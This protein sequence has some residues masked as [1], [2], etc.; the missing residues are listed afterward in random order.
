[1]FKIGLSIFM[2]IQTKVI[3]YF[4]TF[5]Y[6]KN[7]WNITFLIFWINGALKCT[8]NFS[9]FHIL[10]N[11]Y[12]ASTIKVDLKKHLPINFK[13]I[14]YLLLLYY[15]FQILYSTYHKPN[16]SIDVF[17]MKGKKLSNLLSC[18][19]LKKCHIFKWDFKWTSFLAYFSML[20]PNFQ[21]KN[22]ISSLHI[23]KWKIC[24]FSLIVSFFELRANNVR[25]SYT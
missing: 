25:E 10:I 4:I 20:W 6:I 16:V 17:K 7:R 2:G 19:F 5:V 11:I 13:P 14:C 12:L 9:F 1:M 8:S 21:T 24:F 3:V 23:I 22:Q 15:I 18:V